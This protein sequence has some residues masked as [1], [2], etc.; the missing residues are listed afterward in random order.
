MGGTELRPILKDGTDFTSSAL[1]CAQVTVNAEEV[2]TASA[3]GH[4]VKG[5]A[6]KASAEDGT[7]SGLAVEALAAAG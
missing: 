5:I 7:G 6:A 3:D 4:D 2:D 1:V